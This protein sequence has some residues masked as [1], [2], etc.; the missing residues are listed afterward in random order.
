MTEPEILLTIS[1]VVGRWGR[2]ETTVRRD[3]QTGRLAGA[4]PPGT[5]GRKSWGIS[6]PSAL[7]LYGPELPLDSFGRSAEVEEL[8]LGD[9]L[10]DTE[11]ELEEARA[12]LAVEEEKAL[13]LSEILQ[14]TRAERVNAEKQRD[15][16]AAKARDLEADLRVAEARLEERERA[17][18]VVDLL[19][20]MAPI[21]TALAARAETERAALT[22][23]TSKPKRWWQRSST[24]K[25]SVAER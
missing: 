17:D 3:C 11:R 8:L 15:E 19:R 2:S 14:A 13:R 20:Q 4:I 22:V 21:L 10:E 24:S 9:V 1:E 7:A 6:V 16:E 5:G 25:D 18:D 23:T 12:A